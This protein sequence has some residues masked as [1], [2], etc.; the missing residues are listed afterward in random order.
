MGHGGIVK[1]ISSSR[2]DD[3]KALNQYINEE[4]VDGDDQCK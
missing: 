3:V 2:K 1:Q 4:S